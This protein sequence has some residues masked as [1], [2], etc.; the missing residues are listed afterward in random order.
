M[1]TTRPSTTPRSSN[2]DIQ[3]RKEPFCCFFFLY[4]EGASVRSSNCCTLDYTIK[5]TF[6]IKIKKISEYNKE[7]LER[8]IKRWWWWPLTTLVTTNDSCKFIYSARNANCRQISFGALELINFKFIMLKV[9][10]DGKGIECAAAYDSW[11]HR[12]NNFPCYIFMD[13]KGHCFLL[14]HILCINF[15]QFSTL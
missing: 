7:L 1:C 15:Y 12:N 4:N 8:I 13:M 5:F 2:L 9:I 14:H 6:K 11:R 3:K 10:L